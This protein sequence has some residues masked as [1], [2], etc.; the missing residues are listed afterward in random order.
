[1]T[2]IEKKTKKTYEHLMRDRLFRPLGMTTAGIADHMAS[3]GKIDAPW[4]H[5]QANGMTTP[6][7]PDHH[8]P[9]NGRQPVGG[10]Y[11]S[12]A[13]LGK[14]LSLHLQGARGQGRL[15]KPQTF[16]VL[17]TTA[18]GGGFAPGWSTEHPD[19]AQ[20]QVLAHSG[21]I[22]THVAIC[23][24]VP[25]EN[26]ALCVGTNAAGEPRADEALGDVFR[27]LTTRV[28]HHGD[29]AADQLTTPGHAHP[30]PPAPDVWLDALNPVRATVG[31]GKFQV[32]KTGEGQPLV[33][34]GSVFARGLGVHAPSEVCYDLKSSYRRFVAR[35]G[36]ESEQAGGRASSPRF[37][38]TTSSSQNRRSSAPAMP[39]G[40]WMSPSRR[41]RRPANDR[42]S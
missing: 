14:F 15:L 25:E 1:M 34:D 3:E 23:W 40:I 38:W 12:M 27:Y 18:P 8:A 28:H 41:V 39:H 9:V 36:P 22:G 6:V 32:G 4:G 11:C 7:E 10:A 21:S 17:Q 31:Y 24:G 42:A 13:D 20:G 2:Y 19:W 30:L 37:I 5:R 33:L 29:A 16:Q 35:V 26:Y